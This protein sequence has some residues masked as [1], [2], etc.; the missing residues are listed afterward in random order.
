MLT[1]PVYVDGHMLCADGA[2][3]RYGYMGGE[4]L[5]RHIALFLFPAISHMLHFL[6][7]QS[8]AHTT[9]RPAHYGRVW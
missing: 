4:G 9:P 2:V 1:V 8:H 5:R 7:C 3:V 6:A